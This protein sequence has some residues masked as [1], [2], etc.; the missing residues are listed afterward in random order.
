M[1]P[2]APAPANGFFGRAGTAIRRRGPGVGIRV[3]RVILWI[4]FPTL[5][6]AIVLA[7]FPVHVTAAGVQFSV[8]GS[9]LGHSTLSADTTIGSWTFPHV[10][11]LP[12]G[13]H[14]RPVD[15]DLVQLAAA[16]S[17]NPV[18]FA[19]HLRVD[20]V[21]HLP[22]IATWLGLEV[23]L[24]VLIGLLAAYVVDLAIHQLSGH[25]RAPHQIRN[26]AR[27][28][29]AGAL[30]VV[31]LADVGVATYR[32]NWTRDSR[33]SGT[34]AALQ[35]FPGQLARYYNQHSKALDALNAVAAI[36]AGLARPIGRHDLPPTAYR[37]M[38]ISD[39]HL[40]S[41][42][43]LVRQYAE[44]FHISLIVNTGDEAEFGTRAEMTPAYLAQLRSVTKV[45]PMIWLAGNHDS[46]TTV[47]I[48]RSVPGVTVLGT[49]VKGS[50]GQYAVTGQELDALGLHIAAVPDPRV[51]G[52][53]GPDGSDDDATVTPLEQHAM[54]VAVR[55]VAKDDLFDIFGTHEPVAAE[56]L[57]SDLP[58]QI[59]ETAAGHVH[60]Q[61]S[62]DQLQS[63]DGPIT[64][65][66][67]STGAGGLDNLAAH[68]PAPPLEFSIESVA[69]DCQFTK[70]VRFQITGAAPSS[71]ATID[72]NGSPPQVTASTH[73]FT[74]QPLS[75]DRD[76]SKRMGITPPTA[77]AN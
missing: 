68:L 7:L 51:Y 19:R 3:L 25:P 29:L 57:L 64:L 40:A 66:E 62:D 26:V 31:L 9:L 16:A 75:G 69:G 20:L 77:L 39:M 55:G 63:G 46:P 38:F 50:N 35:L 43:P 53:A 58:G 67:G 4:G 2:R 59:R 21:H 60:H 10:D 49:K 65:V 36:Q 8:Q 61:N 13:L 15:V 44:S 73:F 48:M 18:G 11:G 42:Y 33:L 37:I 32:P 56:R 70:I 72:D 54:D 74:P 52:A 12:V 30:I 17:G 76:C 23:A 47:R 34:L 1:P 45:A 6:A 28:S 71:A 41:T 14:I 5:G 22:A 24:G 27:A